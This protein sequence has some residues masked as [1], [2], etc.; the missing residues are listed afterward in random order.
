MEEKYTLAEWLT[1]DLNEKDLENFQNQDDFAIFEKIKKYSA[2]LNTPTF[3]SEVMLSQVLVS[4]NLENKKTKVIPLFKKTIF[5]VAAVLVLF[6][7]IGYFYTKT[8]NEVFTTTTNLT[9]FNLPDN[10]EV[11]INANSKVEFKKYNWANNRDVT[12]SGEAYFKVKKGKKFNVNT[13]LG[14][15]S[16]LGTQFNVNEKNDTFTVICY[17]GKVKVTHNKKVIILN[18]TESVSFKNNK[19]SNQNT[20]SVTKPSWLNN[21]LEF[22]KA[23][24]DEIIKEFENQ[25]NVT[26]K[27]SN[28][29]NNEEFTGSLPSTNLEVALKVIASTYQLKI[30]KITNQEYLLEKL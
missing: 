14:T 21:Q 8:A 3:N 2:E 29:L 22:S 28:N 24:F 30:T 4:K 1:D 5:K 27:T 16:V 7:F 11:I 25:Y 20:I 15:V 6:T 19:I 9:A 13:S 26:I 23:T 12:L 18:P 17:E 10:S